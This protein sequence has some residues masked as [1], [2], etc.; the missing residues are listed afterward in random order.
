MIEMNFRLT[1]SAIEW[2]ENK[3]SILYSSFDGSLVKNP[4]DMQQKHHE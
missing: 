4:L 3:R 1:Y 2:L